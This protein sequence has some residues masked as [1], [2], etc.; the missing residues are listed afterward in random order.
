MYPR[1]TPPA[2]CQ[3]ART[4]AYRRSEPQGSSLPPCCKPHA[5]TIATNPGG[6]RSPVVSARKKTHLGNSGASTSCSAALGASRH[7][8][9]LPWPPGFF[10]AGP[11]VSCGRGE[12]QSFWYY[13]GCKGFSDCD[14]VKTGI[15]A[16]PGTR[17]W[18]RWCRRWGGGRAVL[19]SGPGAP[20]FGRHIQLVTL[21]KSPS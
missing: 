9:S 2:S 15:S 19:G 18:S 14:P 4:H 1:S 7:C 3:P 12:G 13:V 21:L 20:P 10:R 16:G 8:R 6:M 5:H 17:K 11:V